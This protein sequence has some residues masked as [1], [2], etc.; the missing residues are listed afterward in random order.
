METVTDDYRETGQDESTKSVPTRIAHPL[1]SNTNIG[2]TNV[3]LPTFRLHMEP[4]RDGEF[5]DRQY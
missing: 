1:G 4:T 2:W 5:L 3:R